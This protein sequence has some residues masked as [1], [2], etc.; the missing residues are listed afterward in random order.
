MA[1]R[2]NA[3]ITAY[4]VLFNAS[5][6]FGWAYLLFIAIQNYSNL[7]QLWN[8][9]EIPLKIFQTAA[10]FEVIHALVGIVPSNVLLTFFQVLSRVFVVWGVLNISPPSQVSVG[11]PALLFAWTVTE[12]IRYGYYVLHLLGSASLIQWF[13]YTLFIAL[14]PIGVTGELLCIYAALPYV[15]QN[16]LL[17][18]QMP[19]PVNLT[20]DYQYFLILAMLTY[21][22][23]FP[24]LYL[25]MFAQ[26]KKILGGPKISVSG[27]SS[28]SASEKK[29]T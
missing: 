26:R 19:N 24:Q 29:R 20:F 17:T 4:L 15:K 9:V 6:V 22:P 25:H 11:L 12:I 8:N 2:N 1:T 23:L 5:L 7:N 16:Q 13:R 14:Y 21:I 3:L 28:I 18:I 27:S 10:I